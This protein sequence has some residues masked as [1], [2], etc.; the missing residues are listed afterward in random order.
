MQA[1]PIVI[2]ER[3]IERNMTAPN[4]ITSAASVRLSMAQ[5]ANDA[6]RF[7]ATG[8]LMRGAVSPVTC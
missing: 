7:M 5:S 1:F 2:A 6:V 8:H 4:E 3:Q